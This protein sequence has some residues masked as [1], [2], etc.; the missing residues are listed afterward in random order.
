MAK[1]AMCHSGRLAAKRP[2][3]SPGFTPSSANERERPPT[4][5]S[6]SWALIASAVGAAEKLRARLVV[7][8]NG[9]EEAARERCVGHGR[10][11]VSVTEAE[12]QPLQWEVKGAGG[13]AAL[14]KQ[15]RDK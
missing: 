15:N 3:R 13:K 10:L 11:K 2:T 14:Q 7:A 4:R 1:S 12:T 6:I 8:F 9:I 5:R